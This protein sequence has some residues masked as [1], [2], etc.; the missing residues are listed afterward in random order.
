[1]GQKCLPVT[2]RADYNHG[3]VVV[4]I[5]NVVIGGLLA[6]GLGN[7]QAELFDRGG[8][9]LYD[10]VLNVTWLQDANY[11]KT[12]GYDA[13]GRM[14][15]AAA[16]T[17]AAN[18]VYG[19]YDD[20]RLASNSP[21]GA[22]WNYSYKVNGTSDVGYNITSPN[23]ELSYMYF[24]NLG[25]K[26]AA[27]PTGFFQ[28]DF[29]IFGDGTVGGQNDVGL[30]KNLQSKDYWSGT[31]YLPHPSSNAWF[32]RMSHGLQDVNNQMNELHAWAVRSGDVAAVAAPIPE[33]ETYAMM[34]AGLGLIGFVARRRKRVS[35]V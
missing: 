33:P 6:L 18:L 28:S 17:W 34:L 19:G 16:S 23:S 30:V 10:D 13:D 7:A 25:L 2:I 31:A 14:N 24:V 22:D 21:V 11:A 32:F 12:S 9:L 1:M 15:W 35:V 27:S 29:G 3:G 20:W 4:K 5:S 8:G 26:G